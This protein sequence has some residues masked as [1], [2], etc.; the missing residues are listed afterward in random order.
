MMRS[1]LRLGIVALGTVLMLGAWGCGSSDPVA[2][3]SGEVTVAPSATSYEDSLKAE[4]E[5]QKKQAEL[6]AKRQ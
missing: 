5:Q 4:Q 6:D 2:A 1:L 3:S